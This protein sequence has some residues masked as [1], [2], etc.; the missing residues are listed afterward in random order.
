MKFSLPLTL[1]PTVSAVIR[2]LSWF[3]LETERMD[4]TCTWQNDL[5]WNLAAIQDL[6]FTHLRVPFSYDYIQRGDWS[7]MDE[8][9]NKEQATSLS[10][11]TSTA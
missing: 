9:F 11:L 4:L 2:G 6:G 3:G 7:V 10:S 1:L 8:L 5:D